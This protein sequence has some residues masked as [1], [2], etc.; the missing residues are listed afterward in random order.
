MSI[1]EDIFCCECREKVNAR[2]TEGEE[3]YPHREDLKDLPFWICDKCKN[4]VGCHHKTDNPIKPLGCIP[5]KEIK[6][7][8]K[9]IHALLDPL[10][11]SKKVSRK[12]LYNKI[13]KELE[14]LGYK[15]RQYHTA[16]IRSVEEARDVYRIVLKM[17]KN[18]RKV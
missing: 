13:S 2:L 17:S 9:Y 1:F 14:H 8:R 18:Y 12:E 11:K 6:K 15:K 5:T 7:A 4:F 10:W 16:Q 3:I